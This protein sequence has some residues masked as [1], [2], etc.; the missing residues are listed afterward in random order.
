MRGSCRALLVLAL[1]I[2]PLLVL[3]V[4]ATAQTAPA[5]TG[6]VTME[7][8]GWSH[9]R[10][11]TSAGTVVLV[12]PFTANPDSPVTVGDMTKADL[13]FTADGH[14]DEVGSAVE[15]AQATGATVFAPGE[16]GS[17]LVEQG[18]PRAQ[19]V[20]FAAPGERLQVKDVTA[21]MVESVHSS[22]LSR[23]PFT[24]QHQADRRQHG[25]PRL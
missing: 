21:R 3:P 4:V 20:P 23:L 13:I 19:V 12:N 2:V 24:R 9:F 15:I 10:F 14:G 16:L 7:W 25:R 5:A 17:W 22:G 6:P 11:T 1:A 8:L 18:V